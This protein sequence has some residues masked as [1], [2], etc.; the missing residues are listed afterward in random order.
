MTRHT[1][2]NRDGHAGA[3]SETWIDPDRYGP[4]ETAA[5]D[6]MRHFFMAFVHVER[7][8]RERAFA[9]SAR[10]FGD[11]GDVLGLAAFDV[12]QAMRVR[13]RSMFSFC[14]PDCAFCSMRMTDCERHLL[15][16]LRAARLGQPARMRSH[17]MILCEGEPDALFLASV[18]R[19]VARLPASPR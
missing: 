10:H 6:V 18:R 17:S 5:L 14:D 11:E 16:I 12:V 2:R 13:R 19:L 8:V 9:A 1:G 3:G 15:E 7:R 4:A